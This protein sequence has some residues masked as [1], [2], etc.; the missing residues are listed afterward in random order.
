MTS[1]A[2]RGKAR[3]GKDTIAAYL[4][5]RYVFTK[6][7]LAQPINEGLAAMLTSIPNIENYLDDANKEAII[8]TLG[9]SFRDNE[10]DYWRVQ[11]DTANHHIES[12]PNEQGLSQADYNFTIV[13]TSSLD[14]LEIQVDQR[15]Q[16]LGTYPSNHSA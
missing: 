1:I 3:S 6:I 5:R 12:H 7:A 9:L 11:R 10:F 13:N 15:L 14:A 8:L 2:L 16:T 4:I